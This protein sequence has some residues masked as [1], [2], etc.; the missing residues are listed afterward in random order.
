MYIP[1]SFQIQIKI[2]FTSESVSIL[3]KKS[4]NFPNMFPTNHPSSIL[5]T[6]SIQ[7]HLYQGTEQQV[8]MPSPG[9]FCVKRQPGNPSPTGQKNSRPTCTDNGPKKNI[10]KHSRTFGD[11]ET[12]A[13]NSQWHVRFMIEPDTSRYIKVEPL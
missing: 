9:R 1:N 10:Q 4:S 6:Q 7:C 12:P 2:R 13:T 8:L 11:G 5:L 3:R